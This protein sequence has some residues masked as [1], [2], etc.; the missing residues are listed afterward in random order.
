MKILS[1]WDILHGETADDNKLRG[2]I[3]QPVQMCSAEEK[4]EAWVKDNIDWFEDLGIRQLSM[5][6]THTIKNYELAAGI[7][8]KNDYI[9]PEDDSFDI[10]KHNDINNLNLDLS[11]DDDIPESM[12]LTFFPIIPN[13]IKVLTGEFSKR[14]QEVQVQAVDQFSKNEKLESKLEKIKEY[15]VNMQKMKL[16]NKL[17]ESGYQ[18]ESEEEVQQL[19]K[20]IDQQVMSLPQIQELFSKNYRSMVEQWAQHQVK[21]D[22]QRFNMYEKENMAF[23]DYLKQDRQFWHLSL[24]EDDYDVELWSPLNTFYY[25]SP[26]KKYIS[27]GNF[28]GRITMMSIADV[29]DKYR[30]KLHD[31]DITVLENIYYNTSKGALPYGSRNEDYYDTT[32][33][34]TD[35]YPNDINI[36]KRTHSM[37]MDGL[38]NFF[39]REYEQNRTFKEYINLNG[40]SYDY[41][42][43]RVT[44][45]Y[46]KSQKKLGYLTK[47]NDDGSVMSE[48]VTESYD[49]TTP[50]VYDTKFYKT[51]NKKSLIYGEHIDWFWINEVWGGK[52][53]DATAFTGEGNSVSN[54]AI[55]SPRN[56]EIYFD[57]GPLKFQFK[58]EESLW[59]AK[60]P[61]EGI[62]KTDIRLPMGVSLI[63]HMK[64]YQIM[65]NLV[66][67]QNKDLLIDERGTIVLLDQN[68]IPTNS[69][70]EDWGHGNLAKVGF[71]MDEFGILP[72]DT[73]LS[74]LGE[75]G[76]FSH[77]QKLDLEQSN[78][79]LTRMQIGQWCKQEAFATVGITPERLG[80]IAS[81]QTATGIQQSVSNS[82]SQTEMYFVE[83]IN[84]LMPRVRNMM[85]NAAQYYNSTKPSVQLSFMNDQNENIMFEIE[86]YKLLTRDLQIYTNFK[87]N[88]RNILEQMKRLVLENNTT[89]ATMYDLLK[90]LSSSTPSE[91]VEIAKKSVEDF[92]QQQEKQHQQ[93]LEQIQKAQEGELQKQRENQAHESNENERDRQTDITVATIR[94]MGYADDTDINTNQTPDVLELN[95]FN[96]QLGQF[97]EKML[98]DREKE[99]NNNIRHRED[100]DFKS[101]ELAA[102]ERMKD[103][104][105]QIARENKNK[106]DTPKKEAKKNK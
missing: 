91:V 23:A 28:V 2:S 78:R 46:W 96:A 81:Q 68:T 18:P 49:I 19:Q 20:E 66:N 98:L 30:E 22:D 104:D 72:V 21:Q 88:S 29:I 79:F 10:S 5:T 58:A 85:L 40:N 8:D 103:K 41:P 84:F 95:K 27:E 74:N 35:Q 37:S 54:R 76:A 55:G 80:N 51:K 59:D 101:K 102:K 83:H 67:N 64:P 53:I 15:A 1:S 90:V 38:Y 70:G 47:I 9:K 3:Y 106:Y 36:E 48:I 44:E 25:V 11:D 86:G 42:V 13:A 12:E 97:Q 87:P 105:L 33:P 63:D 7:I 69:M 50:P 39:P 94:S 56:G 45:V 92:Q 26:D 65:Y 43:V 16:F 6:Y 71:A 52:K 60:L 100:L 57:T 82:Y 89:N 32:R 14:Y 93:Q 75:R 31:Y 61:V 34:Y 17:V 77:F 99:S 24:L 73:S 4:D 62:A